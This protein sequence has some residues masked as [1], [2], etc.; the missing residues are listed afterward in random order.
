MFLD[1]NKKSIK[2]SGGVNLYHLF[3]VSLLFLIASHSRASDVIVLSYAKDSVYQLMAKSILSEAYSRIDKRIVLEKIPAIRSLINANNGSHDGLLA[4]SFYAGKGYSNLI[5]VSVPIAY[6]EIYVYTK[7]TDIK[8]TGWGS[9]SPYT[10]GYVAGSK[11]IEQKTKGMMVESVTSEIQGLNKLNLGRNDVFIGLTGAQ[12]LINTLN[13][14]EI[15]TI[16]P[17]LER[18]TL[19][20]YLNKKH[21]VM[22]KEL[23]VVLAEMKQS[24]EMELIQKQSFQDFFKQC[25]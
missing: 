23:E 8:I 19:Y 7:K 1:A 12:C 22:A 11:T 21:M 9:L 4:R 17:P 5:R 10:I 20:H 13:F 24:G 18:I 14:S 3:V 16:K 25:S 2:K 15:K 6:D